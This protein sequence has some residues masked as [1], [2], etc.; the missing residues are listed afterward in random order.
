MPTTP[1][2]PKTVYVSINGGQVQKLELFHGISKDDLNDMLLAAAGIDEADTLRRV[3]F[4]IRKFDQT[5]VPLSAQ[6][7][8]NN[9][10]SPYLVS[11]KLVENVKWAEM[12]GQLDSEN[13]SASSENNSVMVNLMRIQNELSKLQKS[14]Q[15]VE[16]TI[17]SKIANHSQLNIIHKPH[18]KLHFEAKCS[19][20]EDILTHLK[21]PCFNNWRFEDDQLTRLIE[22]MFFDLDLV[23]RFK[24]DLK[25][26]KHFLHTVR[27]NYNNNPF[28]NFRHAFCVSQMFYGMVLE[29]DLKKKLEPIDLLIGLIST[30]LHD[31][32]HPGFNN[33]YQVNA[34]TELALIYNDQSPLENHH[35]AVGF[36][37]LRIPECNIL[38]NL[39]AKEYEAL[40]KGV[41]RSILSTDMIKHADIMAKFKQTSE[42]FNLSDPEHR[43]MLIVMMVKCSDISNEARPPNVAEPWLDCLLEEY[44]LQ[45]DKEKEEGLPF[46][47]FMDRDK[48]TKPS[49]QIGFIEFVMLPMFETLARVLPAVQNSMVAQIKKSLEYYKNLQAETKP[50]A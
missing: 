41:V 28:H 18:P 32:D 39:T 7:Q 34:K 31:I 40:R 47:P 46:A 20:S 14:V 25:Q 10:S 36:A 26:L 9:E 6:L 27:D 50:K 12:S 33:A 3:S 35:C 24:I 44:F 29:S 22:H 16:K 1:L 45:S 11:L 43:A 17:N 2:P 5:I 37:L 15:L 23:D 13:S 42:S 48:V 49:A 19:F 30:V 21:T 8:E 38:A 4:H